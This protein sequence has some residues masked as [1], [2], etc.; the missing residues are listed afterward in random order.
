MLGATSLAALSSLGTT[1][2]SGHPGLLHP[3]PNSPDPQRDSEEDSDHEGQPSTKRSRTNPGS[4]PTPKKARVVQPK[5]SKPWT[6]ELGPGGLAL[7]KKRKDLNISQHYGKEDTWTRTAGLRELI[8]NMFDGILSHLRTED[9]NFNPRDIEVNEVHSPTDPRQSKRSLMRVQFGQTITFEF[10]HRQDQATVPSKRKGKA[11]V[12][13]PLGW[14]S[15]KALQY[16]YCHLEL[17]NGGSPIEL[18]ECLTFGNTSKEGKSGFIGQ[19]GDGMK[20]VIA[21]SLIP[22]VSLTLLVRELTP[23][24]VNQI[25]KIGTHHVLSSLRER[26]TGISAMTF[27]TT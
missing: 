9:P 27:L 20:M 19:H 15:F 26:I 5:L 3:D 16:G 14:F 23:L 11:K 21:T 7:Q 17:Y 25:K 6:Y 2:L 1:I 18:G 8:Q 4:P 12:D 13:L 22:M 24:Y 10:R